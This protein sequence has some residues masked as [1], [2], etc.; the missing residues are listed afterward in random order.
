[1]CVSILSNY[2]LLP[3]LRRPWHVH[4]C[5]V[6]RRVRLPQRRQHSRGHRTRGMEEYVCVCLCTATYRSY[7]T[8]SAFLS[9]THAHTQTHRPP[10]QAFCSS[11]KTTQATD[12]TSALRRSRYVSICMCVCT[13]V[14]VCMCVRMYVYVCLNMHVCVYVCVYVYVYVCVCVCMCIHSLLVSTCVS[15]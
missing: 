7:A 12:S 8:L 5:S 6:W 11:S 4:R 3:Q 2:T 13:Y 14:C 15:H 1:M 10:T 9:L